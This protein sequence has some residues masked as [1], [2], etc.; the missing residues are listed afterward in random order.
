MKPRLRYHRCVW[1]CTSY[2]EAGAFTTVLKI[3]YGYTPK[4]AYEDWMKQ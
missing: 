3:G 1:S 4:S 2:G